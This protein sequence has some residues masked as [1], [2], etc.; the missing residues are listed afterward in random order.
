MNTV[1][2][3]VISPPHQVDEDARDRSV[4]GKEHLLSGVKAAQN[5]EIKR[6]TGVGKRET[7]SSTVFC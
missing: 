4:L 2:S 6:E 3:T 7:P 5:L 1:I